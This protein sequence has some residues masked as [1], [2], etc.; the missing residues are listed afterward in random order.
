MFSRKLRKY[1]VS[2]WTLQDS[3]ITVLKPFNLERKGLIQNPKL[4]LKDDGTEEFSFSIPMHIVE[5]NISHDNPIWYNVINGNIVEN[6]RK[7]KIIFNKNQANQKVYEQIIVKVNERHENKETF[8]D[9]NCEGLAFHELGK[10]GYKISLSGDDYLAEDLEWFNGGQVGA[11]PMPSL[12]YWNDKIFDGRDDWQYSIQMDYAMNG[13]EA[14]SSNKVYEDEYIASWAADETTGKV[15]GTR[16]SKTQEKYRLVDLEE[17]NIYNLTQEVAKTF[18]VF[19][20]YEYE[21]DANLHISGKKVIY[22]NAFLQESTGALDLTYA[23]NTNELSREKNGTDIITKMFVRPVDDS[24]SAT[25]DINIVNVDANKTKEDYILNFEY[26]HDNQ[27]I[28]EEQYEGYKEFED[29]MFRLNSLIM[30]LEPK[31]QLAEQRIPEVEAAITI[32]E[33]A[34]DADIERI[35]VQDDLLRSITDGEGSVDNNKPAVIVMQLDAETNT[36]Y[37]K[38]PDL[39]VVGDSIRVY[40]TYNSVTHGLDDEVTGWTIEYDE[41]GNI[42]KL[43]GLT[44]GQNGSNTVYLTYRYVPRTK[45]ENVKKVYQARLAKD[46]ADKES[47]IDLLELLNIEIETNKALV[48]TYI[49]EKNQKIKDFEIMMG[50]ALREGYWQ[51]EDYA[52]YGDRYTDSLTI[53]SND[54]VIVAGNTEYVSFIWDTET[55]DD[56]EQ[57]LYYET[58]VEQTVRHYPC[59][60]LREVSPQD[61]QDH[62]KDLCFSWFG[63]EIANQPTANKTASRLTSLPAGSRSQYGFVVKDGTHEVIPVLILTGVNTL[64]DESIEDMQTPGCSPALDYFTMENDVLTRHIIKTEP[65]FLNLREEAGDEYHIV[66]PRIQITTLKLKNTVDEYGLTYNDEPLADFEDYNTLVRDN[67]YYTTIKPE[68]FI[69]SGMFAGTI[70]MKYTLSNADTAIYLDALKVLK[71]NAYPK[72][73]Y[74]LKV[75]VIDEKLTEQAYL[76]L[77]RIA[78]INDNELK[79]RNVQGYISEVNLDL[80]APKNDEIVIQN[81]RNKF[82]DLF[83]TIV[84]QTEQMSKS[85]YALSLAGMALAPNGGLT[86]QAFSSTL[87]NNWDALNNYFASQFDD[88]VKVSDTLRS[89]FTEAA[90]IL[91]SAQSSL[92]GVYN[93]SL[94]NAD[95]LSGFADNI[96]QELSPTIYNSAVEPTNPKAGSIW[97]TPDGAHYVYSDAGGW[98]RTHDGSLASI[99]GAGIDIDA[100]AGTMDIYA[101]SEVNLRSGSNMYIGADDLQ[102]TGNSRVA[103]GSDQWISIAGNRGIQILSSGTVFPVDAEGKI[104][105]QV[106]Y[107]DYGRV[108]S[109]NGDPAT[110]SIFITPAGID[111]AASKITFRA[112]DAID[113]KTTSSSDV[114]AIRI[115]RTE[116]IY[117]GTTQNITLFSGALDAQGS[118]AN[119]QLTNQKILFGVSNTQS[120]NTTAAELT[121]NQIVFAA[122]TAF[123]AL[124]ANDFSFSDIS[125]N[126]LTGVKITKDK[127][128]FATLSGQGQNQQRTVLLMGQVD[129][130]TS[131]ILLG[132][133]TDP[134]TAGT[135]VKILPEM[136]E[137]GSQGNMRI[138][139]SNLKIQTDE[140]R[141]NASQDYATIFALGSGLNGNNPQVNFFCDEN[142]NVFVRG[143]VTATSFL[144]DGSSAINNFNQAVS[145]SA[146]ISS[147]NSTLSGL[148][149]DIESLQNQIDGEIDTWFYENAPTS[150]TLPESDW[151]TDAEKERHVGDVYYDISAT[152]ATSGRVWRYVKNLSEQFEWQEIHDTA[153]TMALAAAAAAQETADGKVATYYAAQKANVTPIEPD[154]SVSTHAV[155]DLWVNTSDNNKL[156]RYNGTTWTVAETIVIEYAA[157]NSSSVAPTTGWGTTAPSWTVGQ[158]IWQR[159][160][161]TQNGI[162]TYS[163][164][165]CIQAAGARSVSISGAQIFTVDA[166]NGNAVTPA[167]ITLTAVCENLDASNIQWYYKSGNNWVTDQSMVGA[168]YTVYPNGA[169]YTSTNEAQFKAAIL[170]SQNVI[171][172]EDTITVAKISNGVNGVSGEDAYTILLSNE[173]HTF[174]GDTTHA[175]AGATTCTVMAYKGASAATITNITY[176]TDVTGLTI[177]RVDSV[178]TITADTNLATGGSLNIGIVVDGITFTKTFSY[179]VALVGADGAQGRSVQGST[180]LY[181]LETNGSTPT[182]DDQTTVYTTSTDPNVWTEAMPTWVSG[183]H[184]YTCER[185]TWSSGTS[186]TFSTPCINW[187]ITT[188]NQTATSA[189]TNAA[190]AKAVTDAFTANGLLSNYTWGGT[191]YPIALTSTGNMLIG[192]T[193][194]LT[195][196]KSANADD[197]AAVVINNGGIALNAAAI[198]LTSGSGNN[199]NVINLGNNGIDLGTSGTLTLSSSGNLR[200]NAGNFQ[201]D[202]SG[203]VTVEGSITATSG[204]IGGWTAV[205][206]TTN[207]VTTSRLSSGSGD[208]TVVL[209]SGTT[210]V[211]Y[212]IWAGD[213][214][215]G[216]AEF[217]VTR[218][219][220]LSATGATISGALTAGNTSNIGGWI[221]N[222][223]ILYSGTDAVPG[224]ATATSTYVALDSNA[225][226]DYAIWAGDATASAAPFRVKRDGTV[227]LT[228]LKAIT[229]NSEG[230][231]VEQN[232]NLANYPFWPVYNGSIS[233]TSS[234]NGYCTSITLRNGT[235]LNFTNP[236]ASANYWSGW[237]GNGNYAVRWKN[238]TGTIIASTS[239]EG[240]KCDGDVSKSGSTWTAKFHIGAGEGDEYV[241]DESGVDVSSVVRAVRLSGSWSGSTYTVSKSDIGDSSASV[242]VRAWTSEGGGTIHPSF[243][244]ELEVYAQASTGGSYVTR[245]TILVQIPA[246]NGQYPET[247]T[248]NGTVTGIDNYSSIVIDVP[249]GITPSGNISITTNGT[250]DVTNYA[251]AVVNVPVG[252]F[253]SGNYAFTANTSSP[254]DIS[255]YATATVNVPART[256]GGVGGTLDAPT[257]NIAEGNVTVTYSNNQGSTANVPGTF[258]V[259]AVISAAR[260]GYTAGTFTEVGRLPK[261]VSQVTGTKLGSY[262]S[263]PVYKKSGNTYYELD[264]EVYRAGDAYSYWSCSNWDTLYSKS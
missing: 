210:G 236:T 13:G 103:I 22:Y 149:T 49:A 42:T 218:G 108:L 36:R 44:S 48:E 118:S 11:E 143:A 161:I 130:N 260:Q 101:G 25:G 9:V 99:T 185:Y 58:G 159:T 66:Y 165:T 152:S 68:V 127:I 28:S 96:Q 69:K 182:I 206:D 234:T 254:V 81:Y 23:Y 88:R 85:G 123:E 157:G 71:E 204:T 134:D 181:Y 250:H 203:N 253:P 158:Y 211:N 184:Y 131:G 122:G 166:N 230:T 112:A 16:I 53:Q 87:G 191:T 61:L 183:G 216:S 128:G 261:T 137:I 12:K 225:A 189:S 40:R 57:K 251:N 2:I 255:G 5:D 97:I 140:R 55:I 3:F 117:L 109:V 84:A 52:D 141:E 100:E 205:Y 50:P 63:R 207:N 239:L 56:N 147:I 192:A 226:D 70:G 256:A 18:G 27:I 146:T 95:I 219:G 139:T 264:Y 19:C 29:E 64:M 162:T 188:A 79:L 193:T 142:G 116:G 45:Y 213:P 46:Q 4:V 221:V 153:T 26:L 177:S 92:N 76:L 126:P 51:P 21:H 86:P 14:L 114:S 105:T 47:N 89:I 245:D 232:V 252:V 34:I 41:F 238:S 138:N 228:A 74:S 233:S 110:T 94:Q 107:D 10:V 75:M 35:N 200:I 78:N 31:I 104:T 155:G 24:S 259:A 237:S 144:L 39:G 202:N 125:Q 199:V 163:N 164:T 90:E 32:A 83:S 172:Y 180:I 119:V 168:T 244:D 223:G 72:V 20:R 178:L 59:I 195:I 91:V 113:I 240:I 241:Y 33:N 187:G 262:V 198:S 129:S 217:S 248:A 60:D 201:I 62:W 186:P 154:I 215:P 98:N 263:G 220:V 67:Y 132:T 8:C 135:Y 121:E 176:P 214:T 160:A 258:N 111:M 150:S 175:L 197:G 242:S 73:S 37:L 65:T 120:A 115:N 167:S 151:T 43:T 190:A 208:N 1:E 133:G 222:N 38:V 196:A 148:G 209:D 246:P 194:G 170:N 54:N 106:V 257:G 169:Y 77:G 174:Q 247:I 7:I 93:L 179:S 124:S 171:V 229:Y 243:G 82:E 231:A 136:F 15:K 224:D 145:N 30:P 227:Y 235:V 17:S 6:L 80:D 102:I 156:Y 173:N 212:A 249:V